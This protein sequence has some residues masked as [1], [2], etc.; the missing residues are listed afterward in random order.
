MAFGIFLFALEPLFKR[1]FSKYLLITLIASSFHITALVAIP[2]FFIAN[3][4]FNTTVVIAIFT[5]LLALVYVGGQALNITSNIISALGTVNERYTDYSGDFF[6]ST[7]INYGFIHRIFFLVLIVYF[8]PRFRN[9]QQTRIIF[10][11]AMISIIL[12]P[13]SSYILI[14]KRFDIYLSLFPIWSTLLI[15]ESLKNDKL[16]LLGLILIYAIG[17]TYLLVT[18]D[19]RYIPYSNYI[20]YFFAGEQLPYGFRYMFNFYFSPYG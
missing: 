13:L 9:N 3:L 12:Y 6:L 10:N 4:R 14:L 7:N 2:Y 15:L 16:L 11:L 18:G 5:T 19:Y 17:R 20:V 1:D 8:Y